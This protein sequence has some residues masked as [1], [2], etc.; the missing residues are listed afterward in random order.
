MP[1]VSAQKPHPFIPVQEVLGKYNKAVELGV[2]PVNSACYRLGPCVTDN[3]ISDEAQ[4]YGRLDTDHMGF[5]LLDSEAGQVYVVVV[6][7]EQEPE[8]A[9]DTL[10]SGIMLEPVL[11]RD[12]GGKILRMKGE[13]V[14]PRKVTEV[15]IDRYGHAASVYGGGF[16]IDMVEE[17]DG[18][19]KAA[20]SLVGKPSQLRNIE[21]VLRVGARCSRYSVS[22][23]L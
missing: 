23:I 11:E 19:T 14:F 7:P 22:T 20:I 8:W 1:E 9:P 13:V 6:P 3:V 16:A 15:Q 2:A 10:K 17:L 5:T 4:R 12:S 21:R 18:Q